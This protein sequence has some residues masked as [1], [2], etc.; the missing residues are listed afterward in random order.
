MKKGQ[1]MIKKAEMDKKSRKAIIIEFFL[2]NHEKGEK[3]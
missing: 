2:G 3:R 1:I